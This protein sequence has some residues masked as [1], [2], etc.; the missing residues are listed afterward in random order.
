[1]DALESFY[2][3]QSLVNAFSLIGFVLVNIPLYWHLEAWN[4]GCVLFIFWSGTQCLFQFINTTI[5]R[6]NVINWAP[7]WCDITSRWMLAASI[8][9]ITASLII[10][11]R[12]YY[13]AIIVQIYS[14]PEE[15]RRMILI[16][17]FIGLGLPILQVILYYFIQGHRFD[18]IEG[19]GCM[20]VIPNTNISWFLFDIW[21]IVIGLVSAV[22]CTL[23]IRAF[24]KQR[25]KLNEVISASGNFSRYFRLMALAAVELCSTVPLAT[26]TLIVTVQE[27][28]YDWDGSLANLHYDF[29]SV[30]QIPAISLLT[31][32]PAAVRSL[33]FDSWTFI[34][35]ALVFFAFFGFAQEAR[36]HY[37]K[38]F[39]VIARQLGI[40]TDLL[41]RVLSK[42]SI[43]SRMSGGASGAAV[44]IP[45]FLQHPNP[46]A[47][48]ASI[49]RSSLSISI[50]A[51]ETNANF[52]ATYPPST[53][54]TGLNTYVSHIDEKTAQI[55]ER[56][57]S[58][59][60]ELPSQEQ[61]LVDRN[62]RISM[63]RPLPDVPASV[64][65]SV[66]I[67]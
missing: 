8:G 45:D 33:A 41:E 19:F 27:P 2:T 21:P 7:V 30:G 38:A 46:N 67:V 39:K 16:D 65:H 36:S 11:R 54:S 23:T 42:S 43:P 48:A 24:L 12:L 49:A 64:R 1:M 31:E 34:G 59:L 3:A 50:S 51:Y 37:H 63:D 13:I 28:V 6:D 18:I 58:P 52:R 10:N 5:W 15:K 40:P 14:T 66:D 47:D 62:H 35:C 56:C 53:Y 22:Y 29:S 9:V 55:L 20:F 32:D 57:D 61:E 26:Y 44:T 17:L 25:K 4:V 60:P